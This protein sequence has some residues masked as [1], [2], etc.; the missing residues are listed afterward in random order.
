M[1]KI[2]ME[3]IR[4]DALVKAT[5]A[6][7][8]AAG[9]L[10][11]TVARIAKRAG[12]SSALAHHY[13]GGKEQIFY[14]A[15][16]RILRDFQVVVLEHYKGIRTP[17]DR[18]RAILNACFAP[19]CFDAATVTAWMTFY[20]QAQTSDPARR[21]LQLYQ[22]RLHSNLVYAL[23]PLT[24]DADSIADGVG[25]MIDGFY[26]RAAIAEGDLAQSIP[27]QIESLIAHK[28]SLGA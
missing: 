6:E 18:L 14:A 9:S 4:R 20:A 15:M 12:M 11:V 3:P 2:G 16:R 24:N 7:V 13:F 19:E 28:L 5:I 22:A 26:L 25:S 1:P 21:L 17:H 23:R 27:A 8:G 10:D